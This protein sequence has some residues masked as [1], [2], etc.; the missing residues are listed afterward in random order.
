MSDVIR[1]PPVGWNKAR[2]KFLD[3]EDLNDD[4]ADY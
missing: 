4:F 3:Q 2:E 1:K